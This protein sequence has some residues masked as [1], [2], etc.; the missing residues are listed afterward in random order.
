[1]KVL[2]LPKE[3]A[4]A[5]SDEFDSLMVTN[6]SMCDYLF[7]NKSKGRT[8][9]VITMPY[10][11]GSHAADK[12]KV[13]LPIISQ[14]EEL[15]K[16]GFVHGDIRAFNTVFGKEDNKGWLIDFD[17]RG[18]QIQSKYPK[19]Y[20]NCLYDGD[21]IGDAED[22]SK[23]LKWHDWYTLGHLIFHIHRLCPA[24]GQDEVHWMCN[25]FTMERIWE[26][27]SRDLTPEEI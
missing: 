19:G 16:K 15:H 24:D 10:Q 7:W 13:F 4:T 8:L 23:I 27:C 26:E 3:D 21:H 25:I 6:E 11:H 14:L 1:M 18:K 9:L 17:F 12:P 22:E 2:Q 20:Q 5:D